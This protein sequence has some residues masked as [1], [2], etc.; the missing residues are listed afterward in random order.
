[1]AQIRTRKGITA[2]DRFQVAV[3]VQAVVQF[4]VLRFAQDDKYWRGLFI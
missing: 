1:M 4:Q 2:N 3:L